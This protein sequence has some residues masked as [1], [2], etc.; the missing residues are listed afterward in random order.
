MNLRTFLL[1]LRKRFRFAPT[2]GRDPFEALIIRRP[3]S[4]HYEWTGA[5]HK[6]VRAW[7]L[8]VDRGA[9]KPCLACDHQF[10]MPTRMAPKLGFAFVPETSFIIG[11]CRECDMSHTD[12]ELLGKL[13]GLTAQ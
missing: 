12:N 11:I 2:C 9:E 13:Y 7:I 8:E 5:F 3:P 6:A 10:S 1:V 4:M